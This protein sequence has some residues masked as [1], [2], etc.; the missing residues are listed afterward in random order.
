[1]AP[2]QC[3]VGPLD[4][5]ADL[6]ALGLILFEMLAGVHPFPGTD[7]RR[8]MRCQL[9]MPTPPI[10]SVAPAVTVPASLEAVVRRLTEKEPDKRYADA[11]EL[12][13]ALAAVVKK[14]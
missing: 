14:E 12:L 13:A 1:M 3:V 7:A 4:G 5:R 6:Y 2:E 8:L 9:T 11:T 10:K